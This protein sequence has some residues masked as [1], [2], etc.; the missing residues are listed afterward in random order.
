MGNPLKKC[1]IPEVVL[2]T[3]SIHKGL[4]HGIVEKGGELIFRGFPF[5]L[6]LIPSGDFI[7][8]Q[9]VACGEKPQKI[10]Y[11]GGRTQKKE[12]IKKTKVVGE[13]EI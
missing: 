11:Y 8:Y 10:R 13:C 4:L 1:I 2:D 5:K 6:I 3:G 9:L 7:T 12:E